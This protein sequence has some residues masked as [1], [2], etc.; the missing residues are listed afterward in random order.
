MA[1]AVSKLLAI[2]LFVKT[3][4]IPQSKCKAITSLAHLPAPIT[5]TLSVGHHTA[6]VDAAIRLIGSY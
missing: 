1:I 5:T 2:L 6:I 4:Y 3:C